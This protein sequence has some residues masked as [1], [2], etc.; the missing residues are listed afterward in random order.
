MPSSL[1]ALTTQL[2][3][4]PTSELRNH[5]YLATVFRALGDAENYMR[6]LSE[7]HRIGI[8]Q[9]IEPVWIGRLAKLYFRSGL[10]TEAHIILDTLEARRDSNNV[11]DNIFWHLSKGEGAVVAEQYAEATLQLEMAHTLQ[12]DNY[13][14]ESLA[15]GYMMSGDLETARAKYE[16]LISRRQIGWEGQEY[17]ILAHYEL[18]GIYEA[19]GD[20]TRAIEYYDRFL[21]IWRDGDDDLLALRAART[22]LQALSGPG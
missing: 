19:L 17:W 4:Y 20:T 6:E 3:D 8:S 10:T 22:R 21:N 1:G 16:E 11:S 7:A 5:L 18:G 2:L 9:P 15:Y 14:L 13:T 12:G